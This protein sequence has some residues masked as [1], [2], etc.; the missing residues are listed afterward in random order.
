MK[1]KKFVLTGLLSAFVLASLIFGAQTFAQKNR[2]SAVGSGGIVVQSAEGKKVRRQFS[3]SARR[4]ADGTVKGRANLHNA[5]FTGDNGKKYAASFDISCMKTMGNTA[6]LGGFIKRTN[7]SNLVDAAYFIVQDN[8]EPG[9][10]NDK[11]SGVF[12]FDNDPNTTGSPA[13]CENTAF[14]AFPLMNID[15][16]NVKVTSNNAP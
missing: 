4:E 11:I 12:F 6:V 16:G 1:T 9:K 2:E 3:F 7:D 8:G 14:D 10:D 5:T 13:A 15:S